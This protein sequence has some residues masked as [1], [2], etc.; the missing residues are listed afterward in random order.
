[1]AGALRGE[2]QATP[3]FVD[4]PSLKVISPVAPARTAKSVPPPPPMAPPGR[5]P[6]GGAPPPPGGPPPPAP[7]GPLMPR[8]PLLTYKRS[9]SPTGVVLHCP[10]TLPSSQSSLPVA[11]SYERTFLLPAVTSS[12]RC[13]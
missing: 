9:S 13:L 10:P 11:G 4:S 12:V 8:P 1:M 3:A 7:G 2:D 6:P 5:P